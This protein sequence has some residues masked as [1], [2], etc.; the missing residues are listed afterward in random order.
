MCQL[1]R[2]PSKSSHSQ[3]SCDSCFE[4][5]IYSS[6]SV[7]FREKIKIIQLDEIC[8]KLLRTLPVLDAFR[9]LQT[10]YILWVR[11]GILALVSAK[12][13]FMFE[14]SL[15]L[16]GLIAT[17][18]WTRRTW[19]GQLYA[20]EELNHP[21]QITRRTECSNESTQNLDDKSSTTIASCD[22]MFQEQ[23]TVPC[24]QYKHIDLAKRESPDQRIRIQVAQSTFLPRY[25]DDSN[26]WGHFTDF[27]DNIDRPH[28]N[29]SSGDAI[30]ADPFQSLNKSVRRIRGD[31][32]SI[33][34][35]EKLEEDDEFDF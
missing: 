29:I 22:N 14:R 6:K 20:C 30:L 4:D 10:S 3:S 12:L 18:Y 1:H 23:S 8:S 17:R 11:L 19:K 15:C 25:E 35:L 9:R 33:C 16:L 7:D 27:Q 5:K 26:E 21:E 13:G 24:A 31:K 2:I 28:E 32:L 34:K